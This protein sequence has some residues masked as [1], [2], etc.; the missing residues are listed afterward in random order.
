MIS[1]VSARLDHFVERLNQ[2]DQCISDNRGKIQSLLFSFDQFK[3][4]SET[5]ILSLKDQ[6]QVLSESSGFER[7]PSLPLPI[8]EVADPEQTVVIEGLWGKMK[9]LEQTIVTERNAVKGLHDMVVGLSE[10]GSND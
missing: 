2:Q 3:I 6:L 7:P 5:Q 8:V 10:K 4:V 1:N 9:G